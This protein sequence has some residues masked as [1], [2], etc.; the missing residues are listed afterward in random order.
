MT[1]S[2]SA[3]GAG[4]LLA[5]RYAS[6]LIDV[7]SQAGA[8]DAIH[9]DLSEIL[10]VLGESSDLQSLV[11][12][13]VY[14]AKRQAEAM[15]EI[16]RLGKFHSVTS[17]FLAVLATNRRLNALDAIIRAFYIELAKRQ[18]IIEAQ[19]RTAHPLT[20]EQEDRLAKELAARTGQSIRLSIEVDRQLLGGMVI[21]LGSQ[22]I[23]DS[24]KTKLS[25]LQKAMMS[26]SNP[27]TVSLKE[28]G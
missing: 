5:S 13:P 26:N 22:M 20:A 9:R 2:S 25:R 28:V 23:D 17:N 6:S 11:R 19:V 3:S 10:S 24:L 12:S 21:T 8:L 7:A 15:I 4:T 1:K 18:G 14:G 27:H 16:A